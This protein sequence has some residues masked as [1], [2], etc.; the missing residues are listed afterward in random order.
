MHEPLTDAACR[1]HASEVLAA[2]SPRRT[3]RSPTSS[4]GSPSDLCGRDLTAHNGKI[5]IFQLFLTQ[6]QHIVM[7]NVMHNDRETDDYQ[8]PRQADR[9]FRH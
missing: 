2:A 4:P 8:L 5:R 1:V 7:L 9:R 3:G 6:L